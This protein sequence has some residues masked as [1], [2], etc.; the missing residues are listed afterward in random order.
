MKVCPLRNTRRSH[1]AI[2]HHFPQHCHT[3]EIMINKIIQESA[4]NMRRKAEFRIA[5]EYLEE[6]PVAR[7]MRIGWYGWEVCPPA[8]AHE[9]QKVEKRVGA[10][11]YLPKKPLD[12]APSVKIPSGE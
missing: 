11:R 7:Q 9:R 5:I 3:F 6:G 2:Y 10:P 8:G 12:K 1:R 4:G